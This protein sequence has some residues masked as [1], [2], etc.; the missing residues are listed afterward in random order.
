MKYFL[1]KVPRPYFSGRDINEYQ[2]YAGS[3]YHKTNKLIIKMFNIKIRFITQYCIKYFIRIN[4]CVWA[5]FECSVSNNRYKVMVLCT[6]FRNIFSIEQNNKIESP[7]TISKIDNFCR[8]CLA[9]FKEKALALMDLLSEYI[10]IQ[11]INSLH[12]TS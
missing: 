1:K 6:R 9:G 2:V 12:D 11:V 10:E 5:N 4:S 7:P 8:T 3:H